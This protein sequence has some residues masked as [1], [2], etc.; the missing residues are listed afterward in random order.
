[1]LAQ[2]LKAARYSGADRRFQPALD[3]RHEARRF[4]SAQ[5]SGQPRPAR[6]GMACGHTAT[7]AGVGAGQPTVLK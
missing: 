5:F 4:S 7:L 3:W 6:A 2:I 1:M